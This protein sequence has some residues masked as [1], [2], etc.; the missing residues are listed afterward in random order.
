MKKSK[1]NR[2]VL[3]LMVV[4]AVFIGW[5]YY[6]QKKSSENNNLGYSQSFETNYLNECESVVNAGTT[7]ITQFAIEEYCKCNLAYI[8]KNQT[9]EQYNQAD[10][11]FKETGTPS[12][13]W[14]EA[15]E[16]CF[17]KYLTN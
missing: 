1:N 17:P 16:N 5:F 6:S 13:V 3:G 11:E 10:S 8:E 14:Q 2:W 7:K 9:P 4:L 12:K 15:T